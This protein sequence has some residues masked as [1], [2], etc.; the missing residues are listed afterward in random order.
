MARILGLSQRLELIL[1]IFVEKL[2]TG[3]KFERWLSKK[4]NLEYK[5]QQQERGFSLSHEI[6]LEALPP[7]YL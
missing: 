2:L 4:S 7:L 3:M 6:F 1:Y 5:S